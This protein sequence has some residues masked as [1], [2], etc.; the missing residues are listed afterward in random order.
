MEGTGKLLEECYFNGV[1]A[2]GK[3]EICFAYYF[4]VIFHLFQDLPVHPFTLF[5]EERA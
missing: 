5:A 2:D 1:N 4:A 3:S